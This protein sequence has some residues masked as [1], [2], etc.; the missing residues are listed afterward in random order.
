MFCFLTYFI[1]SH[2]TFTKVKYI[3][4]FKVPEV[5]KKTIPK[6]KVHAVVPKKLEP[7]SIRCTSHH[8]Y[9]PKEYLSYFLDI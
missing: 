9:Y 6:E 5:P 3:N 4:I 7:S 1:L 2:T 8:R